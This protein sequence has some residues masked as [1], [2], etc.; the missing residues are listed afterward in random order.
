MTQMASATL[1]ISRSVARKN[2]VDA[3][4]RLSKVES[5]SITASCLSVVWSQRCTVFVWCAFFESPTAA[6]CAC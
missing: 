1:Q 3:E 5:R 2:Q 4:G 6:L